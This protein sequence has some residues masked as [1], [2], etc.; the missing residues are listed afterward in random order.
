MKKN[1]IATLLMCF[2]LIGCSAKSTQPKVQES[3]QNTEQK[4]ACYAKVEFNTDRSNGNASFDI[5][6]M[7][8][9]KEKLIDT[10]GDHENI[11]KK[12]NTVYI[13][14]NSNEFMVYD[15]VNNVA[16]FGFIN[17]DMLDYK[18]VFKDINIVDNVM[19]DAEF[20]TTIYFFADR[21]NVLNILG[22]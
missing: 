19:R 2:V 3:K 6:V 8:L 15:T 14:A 11:L 18:K 21:E 17:L 9:L 13:E 10:K 7:D 20:F 1:I 5:D 4:T 16:Y 22:K 12:C